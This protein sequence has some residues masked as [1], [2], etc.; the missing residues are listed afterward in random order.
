MYNNEMRILGIDPGTAR[1]GWAIV[2]ENKSKITAVAFD[3]FETRKEELLSVRLEKIFKEIKRLIKKYNPEMVAI[4][5]VFFSSNAKTAFAVGQARGVI[6]LAAQM[7]KV[8]NCSFSPLQIKKTVTGYG[9]ADKK[10]MAEKVNSI[11]K[12]KNP[13]RLDDTYDALAVALTYLFLNNKS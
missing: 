7:G 8:K 3:C 11:F 5:E 13:P 9:R 10:D 1:T 2:D 4:E 12:L 6:F